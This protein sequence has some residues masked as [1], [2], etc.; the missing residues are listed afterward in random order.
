MLNIVGQYIKITIEKSIKMSYFVPMYSNVFQKTNSCFF[1]STIFFHILEMYHL[2][3]TKT[4]KHLLSWCY[5]LESFKLIIH[6]YSL[7]Y[8]RLGH[9]NLFPHLKTTSKSWMKLKTNCLKT[10]RANKAVK[11]YKVKIWKVEI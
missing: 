6:I 9:L 4:Y 7:G 5:S 8:N 10:C 11:S 1:H 3:V 2:K